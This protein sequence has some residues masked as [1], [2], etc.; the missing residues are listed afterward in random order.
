[1]CLNRMRTML[2]LGG[3]FRVLSVRAIQST[4]LFKSSVSL[5]IFCPDVLS[6]IESEVLKSSIIFVISPFISA[7][8]YFIY[9]A[10]LMLGACIFIIP[11]SSCRLTLSSLYMDLL[12]LV[13]KMDN[14]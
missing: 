8:I 12:S 6:F 3:M 11:I 5:L 10:V 14:Y 2:L 9:L 7:N 1:M 4:V 13:T